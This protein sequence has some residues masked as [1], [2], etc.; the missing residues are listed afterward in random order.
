M[1][2]SNYYVDPAGGN[3]TTGDG[4]I[5]TPWAT[6]QHAL[7]T[8]TRNTGDG[9]QINVK[10]GGT[11]TLGAALTLATYGT[12][13]AAAPLTIRGYTSAANDGGIGVIDGAATYAIY[14][15]TGNSNKN[16]VN[17]IDMKIGNCGSAK[18]LRLNQISA[19]INCEIHTSTSTEAFYLDDIGSIAVNCWLHD[20]TG[21]SN[22]R[23]SAGVFFLNN[24]VQ[25]TSGSAVIYVDGG[26]T[27]IAGNLILIST[28]TSLDAIRV[29]TTQ[30][31]AIFNNTIYCSS[32]NTGQAFD[33]DSQ[34]IFCWNNVVEGFSGS[35]G[36]GLVMDYYGENAA[37][38]VI[39]ANAYYNCA[40]NESG[41][42]HVLATLKAAISL[43][44]SPFNNIA[45]GDY[46]IKAGS[47]ALE[48]AWPASI[49]GLAT[50]TNA[51]EVGAYQ[52]GA[53]AGGGLLTHPG[54][55]G[56]ING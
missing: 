53:G 41:S 6:V 40:T 16:A 19:A 1:A 15:H 45:G 32:A 2:K 20:L 5:G 35:G 31:A 9:D 8:I 33:I 29:E 47:T 23:L 22:I 37:V 50:T 46:S 52:K 51:A 12:P 28:D 13:A 44:S 26:Y 55:T 38:A 34:Q 56:G 48:A 27:T 21:A 24:Y 14:D 42:G 43:A 18:V 11:D 10:A 39:G 4:T 17:F 7:D 49:N 25:A 30:G 54:M 3:D 36:A